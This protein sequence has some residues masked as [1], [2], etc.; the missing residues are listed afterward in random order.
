MEGKPSL[1]TEGSPLLID[2]LFK[3]IPY[4]RTTTFPY[5]I[6]KSLT[7]QGNPL[8]WKESLPFLSK[9]ILYYRMN[10]LAIEINPLLHKETPYYGRKAFPYY[11]KKYFTI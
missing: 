7:I 11:R 5:Y 1:T 3:T 2:N 9:E 10:S 6:M 4:Y 8:L